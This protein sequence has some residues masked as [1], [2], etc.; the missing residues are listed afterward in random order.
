MWSNT[1]GAVIPLMAR[2]LNID[3]AVVSA[4]MISTVVDASGLLI[5]MLIAKT[6]LIAI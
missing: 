4:P 1:V 6:L 3:P 2:R 5:Y